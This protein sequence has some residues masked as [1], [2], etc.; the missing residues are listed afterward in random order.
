MN[1]YAIRRWFR[2]VTWTAILA[3]CFLLQ[4][5]ASG[6][7]ITVTTASDDDALVIGRTTLRQAITAANKNVSEDVIVFDIPAGKDR[8]IDL[9]S[10]LPHISSNVAI[11]NKGD[12]VTV[13][14]SISFRTPSFPI[15]TITPRN[16]VAIEGLVITR[17]VGGG[18]RNNSSTLSMRNCNL[19]HN[20]SGGGA[21]GAIDN[22]ASPDGPATLTLTNC[23]L[24]ENKTSRGGLYFFDAGGGAIR[25]LGYETAATATLIDC[26]LLENFTFYEPPPE[27]SGGLPVWD[28]PRGGGIANIGWHGGVANLSLTRCRLEGNYTPDTGGAIYNDT[29]GS[30]GSGTA[31]NLS[32]VDCTLRNNSAN[33]GGAVNTTS[34][35][36][37]STT[38]TLEKCT[39][40]GNQANFNGGAINN[41]AELSLTN[42]TFSANV[43]G[44]NSGAGDGGGAAIFNS[45]GTLSVLN[46]TFADNR[47]EHEAR[48]TSIFNGPNGTVLTANSIFFRNFVGDA[49]FVNQGA[50]SSRG[51]NLSNDSANGFGGTAPG[52][53]LNQLGDKR[54]TDPAMLALASNGGF[55][56]TYALSASSPAINAGD[57]ALA[58]P[59][60]QRGFQRSGVS[61]IGA[62]ERGATTPVSLQP[63]RLGN[64]A[65][66]LMV[67][68]G[69]NALIG[70]F[71]ITGTEPKKVMVRAIGPSLPFAN[72]L[73]NPT[74]ELFDASGASI[75]A[76][77]NWVDSPNKQAIIDSTIPPT[78]DFE[79]AIVAY[80]PANSSSYTAV[81]RG[82]NG[83]TGI[84]V[85]EVYDLDSSVDSKLANI[86]TRGLVQTGDNV[87]IA[88]TIVTGQASQRVII[89][90]IGPSLP[91]AG[92]LENPALELIN[93]NGAQV[94]A[95]D[96]WRTGGQEAAINAT[97]V[98][99]SN[100]LESAI[101]YQLPSN[102]A[103]YTAIVR[104]VGGTTGIAVI[105]V[106]ALPPFS[107]DPQ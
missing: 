81:I 52:G 47:N 45:A 22:R 10:E 58:P 94:A 21:G 79:S 66:R 7:T 71:I 55:T 61:D 54:N 75:E 17:G 28:T 29:V 88:G 31:A 13:Q 20:S 41:A 107:F 100:E 4:H 25:N 19:H 12:P 98:P 33:R 51:H 50:F 3:C 96:D 99:P 106:Y 2:S 65:T 5:A 35:S 67:E 87:L 24:S 43:A 8:V 18:V 46:C 89:R 27:G 42:C 69:D 102:N 57:D 85:V 76:N 97:G 9:A 80:L 59:T 16:T 14:R 39:L 90:A 77:D 82:A 37:S 64:I 104:G 36:G 44:I 1:S 74:L 48:A 72:R 56:Q 103:S 101:V 53:L 86:S 84:G 70:G 93:A 34:I 78:N 23:T 73:Q 49:N 68:T 92:R 105:E 95:N 40:V 32:L 63:G 15:F 83:G 38:A 11:I 6:A 26:V 91:I 60:D 62:Y 30:A